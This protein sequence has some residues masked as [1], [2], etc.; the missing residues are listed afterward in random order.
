MALSGAALEAE[1]RP[2]H[3]CR[4]HALPPELVFVH[5]HGTPPPHYTTSWAVAALAPARFGCR[6]RLP[7]VSYTHL[8]LPTILLV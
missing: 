1:P 4:R 8:T 3:V 7:P 6:R 5:Y 2:T